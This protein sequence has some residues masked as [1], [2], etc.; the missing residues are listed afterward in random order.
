MSGQH[1]ETKGSPKSVTVK[2]V[3]HGRPSQV[4]QRVRITPRLV[5]LR[6]LVAA[7]IIVRYGAHALAFGS[8]LYTVWTS[9]IDPTVSIWDGL[10]KVMTIGILALGYEYT[11]QIHDLQNTGKKVGVHKVKRGHLSN[12]SYAHAGFAAS[13]YQLWST[14]PWNRFIHQYQ[15]S[16][17]ER[18]AASAH[19]SAAMHTV[20]ENSP[21]ISAFGNWALTDAS[22][23]K[24]GTLATEWDI[25]V[26][27]SLADLLVEGPVDLAELHKGMR[28]AHGPMNLNIGERIGRPGMYEKLQKLSETQQ[29]GV[30][31][32]DW[33]ERF[34]K[35]TTFANELL[36]GKSFEEAYTAMEACSGWDDWR[37]DDERRRTEG[38]SRS[39]K[40]GDGLPVADLEVLFDV[41]STRLGSQ[42]LGNLVRSVN[43]LG[44]RVIAI[45]SFTT[46]NLDGLEDVFGEHEPLGATQVVLKADGS[47]VFCEYPAPKPYYLYYHAT[48]IFADAKAGLVPKGRHILTDAAVLVKEPPWYMYRGVRLHMESYSINQVTIESFRRLVRDFDIKLGCFLQERRLDHKALEVIFE[49]A[50]KHSDVLQLG[51]AYGGPT[52]RTHDDLGPTFLSSTASFGFA[53]ILSLPHWS[54]P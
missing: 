49:A 34:A 18:L 11:C 19:N 17:A 6:L 23:P 1:I 14:P 15:P 46:E 43:R 8:A 44:I 37:V 31:P 30:A 20:V 32:C 26:G 42:V 16:V 35:T 33:L 39:T 21:I 50:D 10:G 48:H 12:H 3:K 54:Y 24:S 51:V 13:A 9:Y 53:E 36:D 22:S 25:W 27:D 29:G 52:D 28:I 2:L 7:P 40:H 4:T 38:G 47:T 5:F 45:M 41:K